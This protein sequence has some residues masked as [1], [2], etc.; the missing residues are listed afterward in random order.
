MYE[1][2][3]PPVWLMDGM[4]VEHD[5]NLLDINDINSALTLLGIGQSGCTKKKKLFRCCVKLANG[6]QV[7]GE[8]YLFDAVSK[9][10]IADICS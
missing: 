4:P 5:G 7:C 6:P 1:T 10:N 2:S 3:G 9:L 8:H